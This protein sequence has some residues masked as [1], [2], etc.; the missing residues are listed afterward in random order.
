MET[1]LFLTQ[2]EIH[3]LNEIRKASKNKDVTDVHKLREQLAK[4][5]IDVTFEIKGDRITTI[6]FKNEHFQVNSIK[7]YER[8]FTDR[9]LKSIN[10]NK[11][12]SLAEQNK[13]KESPK[14]NRFEEIKRT[15]EERT[16]LLNRNLYDTKGMSR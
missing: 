9:V 3:G 5:N 6:S 12:A 10:E 8:S 15:R 16:Q 1:K 11:M 13:Q 14:Y 2:M 4:R 7:G